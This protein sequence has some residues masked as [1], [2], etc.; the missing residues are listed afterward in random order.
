[1]ATALCVSG[2]SLQCQKALQVV[3]ASCT[4]RS[5]FLLGVSTSR[6]AGQRTVLSRALGQSVYP[7]LCPQHGS[8]GARPIRVARPFRNSL[9][10]TAFLLRTRRVGRAQ[11]AAPAPI[12]CGMR[13]VL[14]LDSTAPLDPAVSYASSLETVGPTSAVLWRCLWRSAATY[15]SRLPSLDSVLLRPFASRPRSWADSLKTLWASPPERGW[16]MDR[17]FVGSDVCVQTR[18]PEPSG[19]ALL[20]PQV[21][22]AHAWNLVLD[23]ESMG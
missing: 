17:T 6:H 10:P 14:R 19:P 5:H 12:V 8:H 3:K 20:T 2:A 21:A 9:G 4:A 18:C 22:T 11:G 13:C 15:L 1:M 23:S 16:S 7:S